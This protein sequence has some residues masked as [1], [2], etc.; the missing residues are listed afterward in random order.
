MP[1]LSSSLSS[2]PAQAA[3]DAAKRASIE[4]LPV[5]LFASVMGIAGLALA[6]RQASHAFGVSPLFSEAAGLLAVA[7]ALGLGTGYAVKALKHWDAVAAEFEHPIA[8]NFFGTIAIAILLLSAVIAPVSQ[9]SAEVVWTVGV[10]VTFVLCFNIA[11]RL[12][13][14][15]VDIAHA[16]P[17]WFIPGVATL[18]INVTGGTMPMPWAHEVNLFAMAVGTVLALVFFAIIMA[19][20]IH[21]EPLPMAMT[22]SLMIMMAPFEVGFLAYTNFMQRIDTFA[23]MLFY[24]GLFLFLVLGPK[25]FRKG[26]PFGAGW[27]ALGFPLA[28]LTGA[29]LK[30]ATYAQAWPVTAIAIALLGILSVAIAVLFAKTMRMLFNGKLLAA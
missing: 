27:W 14:G 22:P 30:Y 8:G 21:H 11:G 7:V 28:A 1:T 9:V 3:P 4:H 5:N 19:R 25:V 16:V 6:W 18:D 24:F 12:L 13:Q 20:L 15:K 26:V 10:A 23:G 29:A 2:T 17:A